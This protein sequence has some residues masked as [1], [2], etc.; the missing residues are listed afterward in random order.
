MAPEAVNVNETDLKG[1][2]ERAWSGRPAD[3]MSWFQAEPGLS[4]SMIEAAGPDPADAVI[5]IGGGAS[6]LAGCLL[7]RGFMDV[8]VLD[9]SGAALA[10]A[11]QALGREAGRVT[12]LEEDVTAFRPRRAYRLWHDR[13][14]FHFLLDARDRERYAD[15]LRRAL[16]PGGQAVIATFAVDGPR[17]C[18]GLDVVRYDADGIVEALGHGLQLVETRRERHRTPSGAVQAFS[19]FRLIRT[20]DDSQDRLQSPGGERT[21]EP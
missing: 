7:A 3:R 2:W 8:T 16:P 15:A 5:D 20:N 17:R 18:S 14:V 13:A 6:S 10:L 4:L 21:E 12:W 1:H 19:Y 9:L 11:R